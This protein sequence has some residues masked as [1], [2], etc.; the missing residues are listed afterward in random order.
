MPQKAAKQ[1]AVS[2]SVEQ[3]GCCELDKARPVPTTS[4]HPLHR[5]NIYK[6]ANDLRRLGLAL[7]LLQQR[8]TT[9]H[10]TSGSQ[11]STERNMGRQKI[12]CPLRM[13]Q[14]IQ[15]RWSQP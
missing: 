6:S 14:T 9:G 10:C 8:S 3:T 7:S 2:Q 1:T 5:L 15:I 12:D 13:A 11:I 4:R